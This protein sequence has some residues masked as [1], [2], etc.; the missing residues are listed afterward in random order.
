[1]VVVGF[2]HTKSSL[3]VKD[4]SMWVEIG[5]ASHDV[6]PLAVVMDMRLK[7]ALVLALVS[8]G[9]ASSIV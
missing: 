8:F 6:S 1:V 2:P 7:S 9:T 4:I 5:H 3:F